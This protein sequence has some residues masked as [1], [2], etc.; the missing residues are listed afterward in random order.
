MTFSGFLDAEFV[1]APL[2]LLSQ[3]VILD[4][5]SSFVGSRPL[6]AAGNFGVD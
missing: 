2:I 1:L 5:R 6:L 3:C 4:C